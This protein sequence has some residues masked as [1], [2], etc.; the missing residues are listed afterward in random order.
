MDQCIH[1]FNASIKFE[2]GSGLN[3]KFWH[4][5]W[6][7]RSLKE[8]FQA[9]FETTSDKEASMAQCYQDGNW[10]IQVHD[11]LTQQQ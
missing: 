4:D 3:I 2:P 9:L 10:N 11:N 5:C 6:L 7:Q 8:G 1:I